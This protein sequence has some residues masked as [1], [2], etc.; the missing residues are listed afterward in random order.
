MAI[1][2]LALKAKIP[3]LRYVVKHPVKHID[4]KSK[5][6]SKNST[7]IKLYHRSVHHRDVIDIGKF[8]ADHV[9]HVVLCEAVYDCAVAVSPNT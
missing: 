2:Q 1:V 6:Y 3:L 5:V 4:N 8:F 7:T 9:R